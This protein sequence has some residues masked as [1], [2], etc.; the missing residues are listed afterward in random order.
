LPPP[1]L[2]KE[3]VAMVKLISRTALNDAARKH[4]D[5]DGSIEAFPRFLFFGLALGGVT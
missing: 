3:S 5:A 4:L 1:Q 2:D